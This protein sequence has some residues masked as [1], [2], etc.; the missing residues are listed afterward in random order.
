MIEIITGFSSIEISAFVLAIALNYY[1]L[2]HTGGKSSERL[3]F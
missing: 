3:H 1:L 2:H